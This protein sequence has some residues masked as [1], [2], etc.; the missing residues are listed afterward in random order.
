VSYDLFVEPE[1]H[2]DDRVF[3]TQGLGDKLLVARKQTGCRPGAR[4]DEGLHRANSKAVGERHRFNQFASLVAHQALKVAMSPGQLVLARQIVLKL[5]HVVG[6]IGG[7]TFGLLHHLF[8]NAEAV[9]LRESCAEAIWGREYKPGQDADALDVA[10]AR[11]R[12][13]LK[14]AL[15]A[16]SGDDSPHTWIETRKSQGYLLHTTPSPKQ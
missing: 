15:E 16:A 4:A 1:I 12:G 7:Q 14:K 2:Q 10:I 6:Q 5:L 3:L 11:V 13:H 9:C 8:Q